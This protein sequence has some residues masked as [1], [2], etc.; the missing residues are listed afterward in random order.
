MGPAS[1]C[2]FF[3]FLPC[4]RTSQL[5]VGEEA[6]AQRGRYRLQ[7]SLPTYPF[8]THPTTLAPSPSQSLL[9][10]QKAPLL[11]NSPPIQAAGSA[12]RTFSSLRIN[13]AFG[14][15]SRGV[16]WWSFRTK[17]FSTLCTTWKGLLTCLVSC[18]LACPPCSHEPGQARN[19]E[20][21]PHPRDETK[22]L[23]SRLFC[24]L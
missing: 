17:F 16:Q 24:F 9:A 14:P 11:P 8:C 5:E 19:S 13:G 7:K 12:A 18:W 15:W 23:S 4:A 22:T 1:S 10:D 2:P 6:Q 21:L 3:L 20:V